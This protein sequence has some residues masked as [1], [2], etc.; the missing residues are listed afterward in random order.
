MPRAPQSP[1]SLGGIEACQL[2]LLM[3]SHGLSG[4]LALGLFTTTWRARGRPHAD[5]PEPRV[6][7]G[8]TVAAGP[9][10]DPRRRRAA[11]RGRGPAGRTLGSGGVE[12][13]DRRARGLVRESPRPCT[14]PALGRGGPDAG[15]PDAVS[16]PVAVPGCAMSTRTEE[17]H[18]NPRWAKQE[19]TH[20]LA[21]RYRNYRRWAMGRLLAMAADLRSLR[22]PVSSNCGS[23][24]V[25][26]AGA[27]TGR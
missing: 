22:G 12:D 11:A 21:N 17:W 13:H 9:T 20:G 6:R 23:H 5:P 19:I 26:C 8:G 3:R 7:G 27:S 1:S 10:D 15:R 14:S 24:Q 16:R 25:C 4:S 18:T 2:F